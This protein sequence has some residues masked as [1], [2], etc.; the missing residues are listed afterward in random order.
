M[1]DFYKF[2]KTITNQKE[3]KLIFV[4]ML[5]TKTYSWASDETAAPADTWIAAL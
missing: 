2:L 4:D 5:K 1:K 3:Y